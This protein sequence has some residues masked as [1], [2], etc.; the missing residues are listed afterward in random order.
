MGRVSDEKIEER[1][2]F[3]LKCMQMMWPTY[4]VLDSLQFQFGI[5]RTAA[6]DDMARARAK[7]REE[8]ETSRSEKRSKV[9][10]YLEEIMSSSDARVREK[11]RAVREYVRLHALQEVPPTAEAV[12]DANIEIIVPDWRA[13]YS[14]KLEAGEVKSV[15]NN[16]NGSAPGNG[17]V[18]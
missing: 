12:D 2:D 11:I 10:A 14:E 6:R 13:M 18:P 17:T 15:G 9:S 4:R 1:A 3:A 7:M 16:G 8:D 5:S